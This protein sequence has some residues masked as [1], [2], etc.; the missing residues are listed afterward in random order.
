MNVQAAG[1]PKPTGVP[2][3]ATTTTPAT[4]TGGGLKKWLE[5]W[6]APAGVIVTVITLIGGG[7]WMLR[8]QMHEMEIRMER[9][10]GDL[11]VRM[12]VIEAKL[13]LLIEGMDLQVGPPGN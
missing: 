10:I 5:E 6:G 3:G 12:G 2:S 11:E 13:D 1:S 8:S 9:R 4:D 7:F